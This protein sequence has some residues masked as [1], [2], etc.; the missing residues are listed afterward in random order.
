MNILQVIRS[1][2]PGLGGT[3]EVLRQSGEAMLAAAHHVESAS[4]D[5]PAAGFLSRY[6]FPTHALGPGIGTYG[7][8][9]RFKAW[10]RENAARYDCVLV[11]GI[12]AYHSLA[13]WQVLRST[14]VPYLVF[15]HGM[16]DPWFKRR[17]PLKHLKKWL[18]WPWADYRV[19]RDAKAVLFTC[20]EER[21]RAR[22]SFWLYRCNECVVNWGI[23]YYS[24]GDPAAQ[25][26]AF[27]ERYPELRGKRLALF[28]GRIHPKKGCDLLI[29]AFAA[30]L[31]DQPDWHLVIAG[32][33]Q[34]GLQEELVG[35]ARKRNIANRITWTGMILGNVKLGA[36]QASEVFVLPSHQENFGIVVP[37]ALSCGLPALISKSVNIWRE[38][39]QDGAG[40]VAHDDFEG[41][42]SLFRQWLAMTE[43][44][45]E[46]MK[47]RAFECFR[48]RFEI[49]EATGALLRELKAV[50]KGP[51]AAVSFD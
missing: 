7:Y 10:L 2:N 30:V 32:P 51:G 50:A 17:Y 16:L 22:E 3:V 5:A 44:E 46:M 31:G 45:R 38:V 4:M 34:V 15:T 9:S 29:E 37:E 48:N 40:I 11:H 33:D 6:P 49:G 13:T 25:K 28:L 41:T 26:Q 43:A 35:L 12:W 18:Y 27:L 14:S 24:S 42:C 8:S 39:E 47:A 21:R 1:L 19:L 36:I 20:E 23:P